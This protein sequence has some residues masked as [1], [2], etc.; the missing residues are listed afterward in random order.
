MVALCGG[1]F[2]MALVA[3]G[4]LKGGAIAGIG[5][6]SEVNDTSPRGTNVGDT[7]TD[8]EVFRRFLNHLKEGQWGQAYDL[9]ALDPDESRKEFTDR[10][11]RV[12]P[13]YKWT[14]HEFER[15]T[16]AAEDNAVV[17]RGSVTGSGTARFEMELINKGNG[18]RV[19]RF[20][21]QKK[22]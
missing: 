19:T 8:R 14:N 16:N 15:K 12:R 4:V 3:V 2:V 13:L 9:T 21:A 5:T 18:W 10:V 22:E 11:S 1:F 17:Y 20:D 7:S 6:K